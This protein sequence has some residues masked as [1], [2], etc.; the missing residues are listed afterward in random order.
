MA[1]Q[2]DSDKSHDPTQKRLDDA[3]TKGQIARSHDLT[4]A[5]ALTG[6]VIAFAVLGPIV[7]RQSG[8]TAR[9]F[10]EQPESLSV[11]SVA[12]TTILPIASLFLLPAGLVIALL[13]AQRGLLFTASNLVPKWSR[14]DP[15]AGAARRFGPEGLAESVKGMCKL[16]L[17]SLAVAYLLADRAGPIL[18]SIQ[19]GHGPFILFMLDIVL[20]VL[21]VCLAIGLILG[22]A[23]FLWQIHLH[24]RRNRMS[25]QELID[26]HRETE[27][28]P[29]ARAER[30]QRGQE[31]ALNRMM[32]DVPK[33]DV[34]IVNPTHFAVA[35]SWKRGSGR[36]PVCV[37]KGTDA[38][39]ARIRSLA[40]DHGVPIHS[41]PPTARAIFATVEI[42]DPIQPDHYKPVAAAIRFAE[43]MRRKMKA[44][45]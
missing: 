30:R 40:Q 32:A 4:A 2:D 7:L 45:R 3:R 21:I 31:I 20:D 12:A 19:L 35:L 38:V 13:L 18:A 36:P 15:V 16:A 41:D 23:D 25:H 11:L 29:H 28:D 1:E 37:A 22:L 14:I 34:V 10:L 43:A 27:G 9:L 5:V 44:R 8:E 33:A 42:G 24:R 39:A 6:F 17:V 26:E